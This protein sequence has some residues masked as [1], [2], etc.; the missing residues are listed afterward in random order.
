[1]EIRL[2]DDRDDRCAISRV[3]E[4]SWKFAY[5]G[6][7]PQDYLDSIP[8]GRWVKTVDSPGWNTLVMLEGKQIIGTSSYCAS[9]FDDWKDYGEIIS[10][11][12]LPEYMGKGYG[13]SLLQAAVDKLAEMGCRDVLLWV[14]AE[15]KRARRFYEKA[16]FSPSG[17]YLDDR[18]S[19]KLVREIQYICHIEQGEER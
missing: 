11:Y 15:N 5:K 18:I 1:M 7:I 3:Y 2:I 8:E 10:I 12:F 14:L 13:R 17:A 16:G 9:R 4:K 19:G 6:M